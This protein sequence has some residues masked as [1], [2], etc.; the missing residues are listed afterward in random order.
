MNLLQVENED[1]GVLC[2]KILNNLHRAYKAQLLDQVRPFLDLVVQIYKNIPQVVIDLFGSDN[3]SNTNTTNASAGTPTSFQSPK[4]LSPTTGADL[5]VEASSRPLQKAMFSFK[6][7]T[8]CPIIIVLL[9]SAHK[10]LVNESLPVFIPH[11]IEMLGLQAAPQAKEHAA[12]AAKG[13]V[14][15]S[16]SPQIKNR[17]AYGEFIVAQVKTMSFLA[18]ALRGFSSSLKQYHKVI[19]DF[20]VRLLE[21]CPCELSAARKELLVATRHILNTDFR[22]IFIPKVDILLNEKVLIGEGLTVHETLRPLAYST[23]ADL[24]HH[25]RSE[26]TSEQ[27]WKTVR[28]YCRNMQD[29]TL[30]TSFQIMSA[31]LLL[32]LVERIM[33]LPD[34]E[35]GRQIMVLILN[36]FV[37]RFSSLNR[38][39]AGYMKKDRETKERLDQEKEAEKVKEKETESQGKASDEQP[40]SD[41]MDVDGPESE[42]QDK[43][44]IAEKT[45]KSEG[46]AEVPSDSTDVE[47]EDFNYFEIQSYSVIKIHPDNDNNE[48]KDAKY[49]FKNLMNFLKTV[50][51]GLKSCNP[52]PPNQNFTPALWQESARMFNYEQITIFRRLFREGISGHLFFASKTNNP[53]YGD[54]SSK[55]GLDLSGPSLPIISSKDEKDLMEAFATVFIHIDP[56]S[57]NEIVDAELPFLYE[58]MFANPALLHIPQFFLASEATSANFSGLLISFLKSK[59]PE[60]GDGN[61][62]KANILIRLF[63]LCFMAVNLF[64]AANETVILPHLKDLIIKSMEYTTTAKEPVVY[65]HLL[66]TLFRSI[67]GGRFELLYKEVLPLLHVLLESLNKL[68]ATARK[69]QERDIYVLLCLTVPVRLSFLV[70]HLNYLMRPLVLALNGS[71]ELVSQGLRTLELC[72]DNLT[73]A[74]FDPIIEPVIGEV[75]AALWKHLRPLPYYHQHSHTTLRVLGKLGGRNRSFLTAPN[76]LQATSVLDQDASVLVSFDGI[77]SE[78]PVKITPGVECALSVLED[79]RIPSHYRIKAFEY[80]S[81]VLK[82]FINTSEVPDDLAARIKACVDVIINPEFPEK[83]DQPLPDGTSKDYGKR[84]LQNQLVEKLLEAVFFATSIPEVKDDALALIKN[85]CEHNTVVELGDFVLEKR[86]VLR[87]F[88]LEENEGIPYI[89]PRS[90][91]SVIIYALSHYNPVVK[92]TGK[93]AIHYIYDAGVIFFGS[94]DEVHR[95]PMFRSL[96]GKLSHT[97]FEEQYF[98]KAGA[99]LGLKT[100]IQD[101]GMPVSWISSRQVEFARTMFFVLKD[102][103]TDV[104]SNVRKDASS[105]LF[106][107]LGECNK[108][109][110]PEQLADRPF[111]QLSGLLAYE[112]GTANF[113]VREASKEALGILAK[114]TNKSVTEILRQVTNIFLGPIFGK[115]LRALPFPM[116]IG[117]IDCISFCLSLPEPL[118]EFN[119]ELTRLLLEALALVDAEDESLTSAHR[120]FEYNTSEQLVQLRIVC[121]QLLSLALT[122]SDQLSVQQPQTRNKIIA[123]FFKTLY[124]RSSKV[125]DAA[126]LGLK[127]V[128]AQN[129][130]IP[131]DLL[132]NGLR[133]ILMNLSDHKR[134]TAPGLEGLARLLELLTYYFK[135]EIG[136]KLLDHLK[137]WAEP[138]QLHQNSVKTLSSQQNIQII[139]AIFN[140]FHL[141]PPTA[142]M[143]MNDL[144]VNLF[145]LEKSLRRQ[146]ESPFR[147]PIAKFL[148]RYPKETLDYFLPKLSESTYG[149]FFASILNNQHCADLRKF[150]RENIDTVRSAIAGEAPPEAKS[151]GIC[152]FTYTMRA[153]AKDDPSWI[154]GQKQYVNDICSSVGDLLKTSTASLMSPLY[155]QVDQAIEELQLLIVVYMEQVEKDEE[156]IFSVI[157]ILN[158]SNATISYAFRDYIFNSVVVSTEVEKRRLYLMK[159]IDMI[160]NRAVCI[161]A[162]TFVVKNI[163]NPI[164]IVEGRRNGD[165]SNLL[166]KCTGTA[167]GN[168]WLDAVHAKIWRPSSSSSEDGEGVG[169]IDHFRFEL[170]QMS[171]LLIKLAPLLVADARKDIIK[172]GWN[173]IKLED[174]VSKQSAYVLIAYFISSYDTLSKIVIQIYVA[175]LKTHQNEAKSLVKQAL[176]LLAPVLVKRVNSPLWAKWPR[177]VLSED[178]HNVSQVINIYQ[179][180]VRQPELFFEFRDH[181]VPSI[182]SVMPKLSFL[183]NSSSENQTLAVD[184]AE[185]I[186]KWENM[187]EALPKPSDAEKVEKDEKAEDGKDAD[188]VETIPQAYFVPFTQREACITYLIRFVCLSPHKVIE[189]P[190]G[191]RI[192]SILSE[193]LSTKHWPEVVVKLSFFER[194]LVQ[195]EL[196]APNAIAFC[197]NA[198][199][200]IKVTLE[201]RDSKW[202]LSNLHRLERLLEK[203]VRSNNTGKF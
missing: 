140:V 189:N 70:P 104:P 188:K 118:L 49:I 67:G 30:A 68:L 150:A 145:D 153:L 62:V 77:P 201:R 75:M 96:F 146:H 124:S 151:V 71:Q 109:L 54:E 170:L 84:R 89:D 47:T 22:T 116:Q 168:S 10:Q 155:L 26:L 86:K 60:L 50:M 38:S 57:F 128:L 20:I 192:L 200:V 183:S 12:A 76:N 160:S 1:N 132:Q 191:K 66:R 37:E 162:R 28:V 190:L 13:E 179:F 141:L 130:K 136:K 34:S 56:A 134:L 193:L 152:N 119:E 80:L 143:F 55:E 182:I 3:A 29:N 17:T 167:R 46:D 27:I 142:H 199:E 78:K 35:E 48:L 149:R 14:Y 139:V 111:R 148:N 9:Y 95:F 36:A 129:S 83:V 174:I 165:L 5:G 198:L 15:T 92:E 44:D 103:P 144:I 163:I 99:C 195:N 176:D 4:P 6:V 181:F 61:A 112:L 122:T 137:A 90:L 25:V 120:V 87:P 173:Y 7:L 113:A 101:L 21:D 91:L 175:L 59:L 18:Y 32:N 33:K 16:I 154:V 88:E 19:P 106:Y 98:R 58:S 2:M 31:K 79:L 64:P 45:D 202:I 69:P 187:A 121:I 105:L 161:A 97:C 93:Q 158:S 11:I 114:V 41:A 82:L 184:L 43:S 203:C 74:Y 94:R 157:N 63:K 171:A 23:M 185:L 196:T 117:Y 126:H 197:L 135:V 138:S 133:P 107:V 115:P 159:S 42:N 156:M 178:G 172:F 39:Y 194:S 24:V 180:I 131:K 147:D 186:L 102:V 108:N 40:D 73:A 164:L 125:V 52:P 169:T 53:G 85:L 110:T 166:E 65:F 100:L 81:G 177:R 8:E 72:V 123:V 51:F 127:K